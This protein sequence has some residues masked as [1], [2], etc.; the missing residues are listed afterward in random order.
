MADQTFPSAPKDYRL[1]TF[2]LKIA[3]EITRRDLELMKFN[4][5]GKVPSNVLS[6]LTIYNI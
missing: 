6:C 4:L 5:Q 3:E 2:L 1:N